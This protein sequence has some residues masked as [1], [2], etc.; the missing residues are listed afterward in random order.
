MKPNQF[1]FGSVLS[2]YA[3]NAPE[4]GKQLHAL[5]VKS[6]FEFDLFVQSAIVDMY[7]KCMSM[8]D[9]RKVF[10]K[11]PER[12]VVSW[13]A[14]I[15]GY[16]QN[17]HGEEALYLLR[18]MQIADVKLD[19]FTFSVVFK[20]CD[21]L[22]AMEQSNQIHALVIK[23]GYE[24]NVFVST[25]LIEMF[26]NHGSMECAIVVFDVLPNR[27]VILWSVIIAGYVQQGDGIEALKCLLQNATDGPEA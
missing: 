19:E 4:E 15:A 12:D 9:A 8:E 16:A 11:M 17:G 20:A 1:T 21:S 3:K 10:D 24:S 13:N 14:V 5:V 26:V 23:S 18:K 2:W 6:G 27:D 7:A 25:T 22:A